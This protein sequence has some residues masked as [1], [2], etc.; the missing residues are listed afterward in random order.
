LG[1]GG[2]AKHAVNPSM[3]ARRRL[4]RV[5]CPAHT[6]RPGLGV[7]PN[8]PGACLGPMAPAVLHRPRSPTLQTIPA[9]SFSRGVAGRREIKFKFKFKLKFK[10]K[11]K[12]RSRNSCFCFCFC[13]CFRPCSRLGFD[14]SAPAGNCR[15]EAGRG[16]QDRWRHGWRHRAPKDGFT[17]CPAQPA[18]PPHTRINQGAKRLNPALYSDSPDSRRRSR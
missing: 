12:S 15:G 16:A 6:A 3:G 13:F 18:R 11:F 9:P 10:F 7:L 5:R 14:A 1:S 17:A 2:G 4:A 8:P